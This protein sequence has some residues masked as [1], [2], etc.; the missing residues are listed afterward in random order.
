M[1][2]K[3][4]V[5][6]GSEGE[7]TTDGKSEPFDF[8]AYYAKMFDNHSWTAPKEITQADRDR[9][10]PDAPPPKSSVDTSWTFI[11]LS[12]LN[13]VGLL[14]LGIWILDQPNSSIECGGRGFCGTAHGG[15]L[16]MLLF[17]AVFLWGF[18]RAM[19]LKLSE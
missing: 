4:A 9:Y 7:T 12:L 16:G 3:H 15:G 5:T 13:G 18:V 11:G 6:G 1:S 10:G 14:W 2:N 19:W 8:D 17:G